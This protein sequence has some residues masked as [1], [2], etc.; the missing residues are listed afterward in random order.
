M[1]CAIK[2]FI[3][4]LF[5]FTNALA[6]AIESNLPNISNKQSINV[7]LEKGHWTNY[8]KNN[9]APEFTKITGV[10]VNVI[11]LELADMLAIQVNSLENASG[12]YDV[13]TLEAGWAKE[14]AAKGYTRPLNTLADKFDPIKKGWNNFLAP[15]FPSLVEILSYKDVLYSVPYN[16]Y[17]MGNH[18]RADLFENEIEQNS[19]YKRFNYPLTPPKTLEQLQ[20]IAAFFTRQKGDLLKGK[21]L[22]ENFYGIAL[23]SGNKPH[24]N[25]EWSSILWAKGGYWFKPNYNNDKLINFN[26]PKTFDLLYETAHYYLKLKSYALP[27]NESFAYLE[28][29]NALSSGK[30]AMWPFAYNNLW[31]KSSEVNENDSTQK[32]AIYG[33]PGGKPYHG[34][35]AFSVAYD[36]K[37]PEAAFWFIR[38]MTS[39]KGQMNYAFG[40]GNSTRKDVNLELT[41]KL[42]KYSPQFFAYKSTFQASMAWSGEIKSHGHYMSTAMGTIYALLQHYTYLIS[43]EKISINKG[44]EQLMDKILQAQNEIGEK[45]MVLH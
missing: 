10:K 1:H 11:E 35:Y 26:L 40:G 33:S 3:S 18:Y 32:F 38:F 6:Y 31:V 2:T 22:K 29:A 4:L 9:L 34:A 37:N 28:A 41:N 39:K 45:A 7:V 20:D 13:M 24:I 12:K 21:P 30:V 42:N 25:D 16:T 5:V 8:V 19:F 17:V 27:A 23:M 43:H 44:V 14:W 15:F 36:S